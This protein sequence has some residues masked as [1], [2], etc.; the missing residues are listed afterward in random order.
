[1]LAEICEKLEGA[2]ADVVTNAL[3]VDSR[4]GSKYLKGAL[5]YGGPCFPRDNIAFSA[6]AR[7][8]GAGCMLSEA[9]DAGQPRPT[10]RL[11]ELVL[12]NL[13]EDGIAAVMG[14]SY[15]A[16]T[17]VVE[18]SPGLLLAQELTSRGVRVL[19]YD[20]QAMPTARPLIKGNIAYAESM[21]DCAV[22]ADVLVI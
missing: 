8:Q 14:L 21:A 12:E 10:L 16:D 4:I 13:P 15:K 19:A 17:P 22:R 2:D 5:G 1:M 9:T 18:Q 11:T 20:P 3:G 7:Q 6:L